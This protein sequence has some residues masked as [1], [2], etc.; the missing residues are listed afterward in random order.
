M[1]LDEIIK[2]I[3]TL[4]DTDFNRLSDEMFIMR[5]EREA[6]TQVEAGQAELVAEL[7]EAG[8]LAKP[9]AAT[10]EEATANP[11]T[12]AP[13]ENPM[14]DYSKMYHRDAVS[15]HS[16]RIWLSTYPGLNNF[17]PGAHGVDENI[18]LDITNQVRPDTPSD[19]EENTAG[20][21]IPFGPGL[22]VQPGDIVEFEGDRYRV[23]SD[24][25]TASRWPPNEAHS[26]FQRL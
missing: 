19:P 3:R 16:G 14:G 15:S 10:I 11:D 23:L 2:G 4:T 6:R 8:K 26:L 22:P 20:A 18:W 21:V 7:Q 12:V 17:E 24:H 13:W 1:S 5:R 9:E 25:T